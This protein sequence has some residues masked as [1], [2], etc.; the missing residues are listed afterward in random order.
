MPLQNT[1]QKLMLGTLTMGPGENACFSSLNPFRNSRLL[2]IFSRADLLGN[3]TVIPAKIIHEP[4]KTFFA[5]DRVNF[6]KRFA[7]GA[8][9][10]VHLK[11]VPSTTFAVQR[12]QLLRSAWQSPSDE[13]C[14]L[15]GSNSPLVVFALA[16]LAILRSFSGLIDRSFVDTWYQL[17]FDFQ[18]GEVT[19]DVNESLENRTCDLAIK[20]ARS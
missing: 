18:A 6:Q 15:R 13:R 1:T 5:H 14:R 11:F 12:W 3:V 19:A 17:G 16:R 10:G 2:R 7:V 20:S 9:H 8:D 4:G